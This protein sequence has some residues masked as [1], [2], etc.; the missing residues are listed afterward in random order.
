MH[1]HDV[2]LVNDGGSCDRA[3]QESSTNA[4]RDRSIVLLLL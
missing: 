1:D 3:T 4:S 2:V